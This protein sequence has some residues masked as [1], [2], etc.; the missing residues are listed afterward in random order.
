MKRM[1]LVAL[2]LLGISLLFGMDHYYR[3]QEEKK[4]NQELEEAAEL[5]KRRITLAF[6][7]RLNAVEDLKAFLLASPNLVK[8]V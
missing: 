7:L 2:V 4:V 8:S 1:W 3:E 6:S 5:T